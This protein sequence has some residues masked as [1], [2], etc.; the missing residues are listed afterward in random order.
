M[1]LFLN[2]LSIK[3]AVHPNIAKQWMYGL[4]IVY[5]VAIQKGFKGLKT[6]KNIFVELLAPNYTISHWLKDNS[7]DRETRLLFMNNVLKSP[8]IENILDQEETNEKMIYDFKYNNKLAK[9]LGAASLFD[10][11]AISFNN[12]NEWDTTSIIITKN[13]LS[14][15][16]LDLVNEEIEVKHS[17]KEEHIKILEK[18]IEDRKKESIDNGKI[19]WL[20][21]NDIFPHLIFCES[22]HDQ[23]SKLDK[24]DPKFIQIRKRLFELENYSYHWQTGPFISDDIPSKV[25]PESQ[26]RTNKFEEQLTILCPDGVR[27]FFLLHSR[28]TPGAGRIYFCPDEEEKTIYI[29]YIGSKLQ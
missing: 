20:K 29:G 7:V 23:L 12:A 18:W 1:N 6:H 5:K 10:S 17:C 4:I 21:R 16:D 9:G 13:T 25:T 15:D 28:F 24:N 3:Q 22:V 14:K 19:L 11:L 27:R 2:E 8:F 26:T